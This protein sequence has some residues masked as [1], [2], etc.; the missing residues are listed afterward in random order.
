MKTL[1]VKFKT[2]GK[3]YQLD[4]SL[5]FKVGEKI[6]IQTDQGI[7]IGTILKIK[8][9]EKGK[10][11]EETPGQ[12]LRK[13]TQEDEEKLKGF[14]QE[15]EKILSFCQKKIKELNLPMRLIDGELSLDEKK[16]TFYFVA[17]D[18]IDFRE[19][20]GQLVSHFHKNI[21]LQQLG[22]RDTAKLIGGI[23]PCGRPLCC[24]TFLEDM[25]SITLEMAKEQDLA[26]VGSS[27][28][29]GL[30]GKLMCCLAYEAEIYR[31]MRENL[32]NIG[33]EIETEKGKGKVIAQNVLR[34]TVLVEVEDG[35]KIEIGCKNV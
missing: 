10:S 30:C 6:L 7:E 4:T 29:S 3:I 33:K 22:P 32:P 28:I 13:F 35:S 18:R 26:Y 9:R 17:E 24:Q 25:E 8:R 16:I 2:T 20:L 21:R 14:R 1:F 5:D 12:I 11:E 23:G 34:Q 27:K 31:K 15:V 19:L